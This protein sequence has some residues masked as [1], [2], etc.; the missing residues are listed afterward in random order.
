MSNAET[1][2]LIINLKDLKNEH[3]NAIFSERAQN[4]EHKIYIIFQKDNI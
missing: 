3:Y 1:T 2:S 4:D